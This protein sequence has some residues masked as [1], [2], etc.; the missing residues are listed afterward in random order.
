MPAT[1]RR[2]VAA[3]PPMPKHDREEADR[4]TRAGE[5]TGQHGHGPDDAQD[6]REGG[7]HAGPRPGA[8][9]GDFVRRGDDRVGRGRPVEEPTAGGGPVIELGPLN[10]NIVIRG[11]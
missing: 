5:Q 8:D 9:H 4:H 1:W 2:P 11:G 3:I 7:E 6:Q 10:D